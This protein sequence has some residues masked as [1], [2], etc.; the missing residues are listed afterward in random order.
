MNIEEG[1]AHG[2]YHRN[3]HDTDK[4]ACNQEERT[5]EFAEDGDHQGSITSE[6]QH[7]RLTDDQCIEIHNLIYTMHE[8]QYAEYDAYHKDQERRYLPAESVGE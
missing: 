1:H 3:G 7:P 8:E 5:A 6:S 2:D 4:K